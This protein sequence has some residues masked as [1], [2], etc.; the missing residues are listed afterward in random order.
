MPSDRAA[1]YPIPLAKQLGIH[2]Q[3]E[4]RPRCRVPHQKRIRRARHAWLDPGEASSICRD[5][6]LA[7]SNWPACREATTSLRLARESPET[8]AVPN[9]GHAPH[10]DHE[11]FVL[12]AML[13]F[14][15]R[16]R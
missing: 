2:P 7:R 16:N 1:V 9:C 6:A 10:R 4:A 11:E 5:C 8:I 13:D 12:E 14:V 3:G 15:G